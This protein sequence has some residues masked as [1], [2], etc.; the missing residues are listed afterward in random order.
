MN[1]KKIK[2]KKPCYQKDAQFNVKQFKPYSL[3]FKDQSLD[4]KEYL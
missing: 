4:F 2:F 3:K 1:D